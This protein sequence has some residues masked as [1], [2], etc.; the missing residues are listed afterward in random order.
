MRG[1]L[2]S[3]RSLLKFVE[4]DIAGVTPPMVYISMLFSWFVRHVED[5]VFHSIKY[6]H[7]G[8]GKM[9]FGV[10]RDATVAFEYAVRV[11]GFTSKH[12]SQMERKF[13]KWKCLSPVYHEGKWVLRDAHVVFEYAVRVYKKGGETNPISEL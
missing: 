4:G 11:Y 7:K 2:R 12:L 5:H 10:P 3:K 6:M 9:S 8:A 13:Q 1:V